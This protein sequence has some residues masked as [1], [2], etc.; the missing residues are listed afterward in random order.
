MELVAKPGLKPGCFLYDVFPNVEQFHLNLC[1]FFYYSSG[2]VIKS[3]TESPN[4]TRIDLQF[5]QI[6][7][8]NK[9]LLAG[10]DRLVPCEF[11]ICLEI[12][13]CL[14]S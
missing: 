6:L 12:G 2:H 4:N 7:C 8:K 14:A 11:D 5:E 13:I 3:E 10:A 1:F 9:V